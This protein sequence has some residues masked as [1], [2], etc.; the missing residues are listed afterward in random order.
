MANVYV[1][2]INQDEYI[3]VITCTESEERPRMSSHNNKDTIQ[4][5]TWV[6][7]CLFPKGLYQSMLFCRITI[8]GFYSFN[9]LS[10]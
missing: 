2:A 9:H 7:N 10:R 5:Y 3:S 4:M 8:N 1:V 6:I